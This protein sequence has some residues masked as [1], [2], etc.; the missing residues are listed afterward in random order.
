MQDDV[1]WGVKY[2]VGRGISDPK[3]IGI[4]GLSYGGY[5]ALAGA[6]FTPDVYSAAV[7]L[8]GPANLI[9][10]LDSFPPYW[11][12]GRKMFNVRIGDPSTPEGKAMLKERSPLTSA[13]KIKTPLLIVQGAN[14][15]R[16][17]RAE[18][19]QV[20][21]ALRDRSFPVEYLLI[22][23]EGHGFARPVNNM[24]S[25]MATEKFFAKHLG[26]RYQEGGTPEVVA[27]LKEITV[28]PKTVVLTPK[29]K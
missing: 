10:L 8:F 11:E 3:R 22:P 15:P 5:A 13:D 1:T 18:S 25:L 2:L 27:R 20:V 17:N 7:D 23:D 6:A 21:V 14:D 26:G 4:I 29:N 19:E 9:T 12:A 24:A 16:V 28:D